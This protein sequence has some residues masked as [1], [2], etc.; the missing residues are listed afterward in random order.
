M[1]RTSL[2]CAWLAGWLPQKKVPGSLVG[3]VWEGLAGLPGKFS[4]NPLKT[5]PGSLIGW[6]GLGRGGCITGQGGC[7]TGQGWLHNWAG[8]LHNW[9]AVAA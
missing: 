5:V 7:I 2:S 8:W 4:R 9:A 3:W 6:L 1:D